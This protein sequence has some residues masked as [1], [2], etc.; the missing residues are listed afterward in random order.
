M[1]YVLNVVRWAASLA[2]A[3]CI[4][5]TLFAFFEPGVRDVRNWPQ[6]VRWCFTYGT[7]VWVVT[8]PVLAFSDRNRLGLKSRPSFAFFAGAVAGTALLTGSKIV[9]LGFTQ[10]GLP[11]WL[12]AACALVGGIALLFHY[13]PLGRSWST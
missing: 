7:P 4:G 5:W 11:V 6:I 13:S 3:C 9:G 8:A 1:R 12:Y 10:G 2:V